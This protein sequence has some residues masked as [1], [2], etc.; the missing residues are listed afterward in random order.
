MNTL[1]RILLLRDAPFWTVS[2][3]RRWL[4]R[5]TAVSYVYLAFLVALLSLEGN[6]LYA[7]ATFAR[8]WRD[9]PAELSVREIELPI[10]GGGRV[11]G[12]FTAPEG[13]KPEQGAII[14]SH[15]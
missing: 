10:P 9:P 11:T 15:G 4:R 3:T 8:E 12:W 5:V 6:L 7:G 14:Y 1:L 2:R 13:W